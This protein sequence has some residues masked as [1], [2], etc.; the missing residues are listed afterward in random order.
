[1]KKIFIVITYLLFISKFTVFSQAYLGYTT[2]NANLR[3]GAGTEYSILRE[4]P[5]FS[6]LFI[7]SKTLDNNYYHVI[8][9]E[10][11]TEGYVFKDYVEFDKI[12]PKSKEK[13]F[14]PSGKISSLNPE[15]TITNQT[16]LELNLKLNNSNYTFN[17]NE[18]RSISVVAGNYDF[19][20]SCPGVIPYYGS[21]NL[22][23]NVLYTWKFYIIE[24]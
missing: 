10:T 3:G 6:N 5:K 19:V 23:K 24:R 1:M 13:I 21:D 12:I 11:S 14:Q 9:I 22:E 17:A 2:D 8:D 20:A 7:F 16:D 4:L 15:I 18:T